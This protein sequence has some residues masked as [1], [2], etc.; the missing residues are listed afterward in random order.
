MGVAMMGSIASS[1][2]PRRGIQKKASWHPWKRVMMESLSKWKWHEDDLPIHYSS[3]L[4]RFVARMLVI[5]PKK[6]MDT[7]EALS[8]CFEWYREYLGEQ[9]QRQRS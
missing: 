8:E 5:E 3:Q 9:W 2:K 6:R 1:V 7:K 4:R